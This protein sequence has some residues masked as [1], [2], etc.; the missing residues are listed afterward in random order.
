MIA[1]NYYKYRMTKKTIQSPQIQ[2]VINTKANK[3]I[4]NMIAERIQERKRMIKKLELINLNLSF[5]V[6]KT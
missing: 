3:L 1:R 4:K 6:L 2:I 5:P